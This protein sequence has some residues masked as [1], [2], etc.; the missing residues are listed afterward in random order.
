[1]QAIDDADSPLCLLLAFLHLLELLLQLLN[2]LALLLRPTAV[3]HLLH[4]NKLLHLVLLSH[5]CLRS[6]T[7]GASFEEVSSNSIGS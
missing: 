2:L 1:M 3:L 4:L 7:L 6:P 5:L